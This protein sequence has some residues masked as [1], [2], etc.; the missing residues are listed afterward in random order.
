LILVTLEDN[1]TLYP[2]RFQNGTRT[3]SPEPGAI[4]LPA[5]AHL[6]ASN[7]EWVTVICD[8]E[9]PTADQMAHA[10]AGLKEWVS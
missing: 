8:T 4:Q 7:S 9:A 6:L 5:T 1:G 3:I 2:R 10:E